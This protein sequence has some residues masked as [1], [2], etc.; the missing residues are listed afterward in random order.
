VLILIEADIISGLHHNLEIS[1]DVQVTN[2]GIRKLIGTGHKV[3]RW[4]PGT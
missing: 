4:R 2:V 1:R 3:D